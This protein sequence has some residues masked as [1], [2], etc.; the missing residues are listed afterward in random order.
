MDVVVFGQ[1]SEHIEFGPSEVTLRIRRGEPYLS[2]GLLTI[3][4]EMVELHLE[5]KSTLVGDIT[6]RG[7]FDALRDEQRRIYGKV[8][9][10]EPG[11]GFPA[12]NYFDVFVEIETSAGKFANRKPEHMVATIDRIPPDFSRTPYSSTTE[13]NLYGDSVEGLEAAAPIGA[14]AL[15]QHGVAV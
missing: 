5:G 7:G 12:E 10:L 8:I 9:E 14:I 11:T 4:T 3:D 6:L 1:R 13:I 15:V 2:R